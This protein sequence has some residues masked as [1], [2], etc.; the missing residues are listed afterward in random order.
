MVSKFVVD[1]MA[2]LCPQGNVCHTLANG[3]ELF[4]Y[5]LVF[6]LF[7]SV[8]KEGV[9]VVDGGFNSQV[10]EF[11]VHLDAVAAGPVADAVPLVQLED[12]GF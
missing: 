11:V 4:I 8:C 1:R 2:G 7:V 10:I 9:G 6:A 12:C 3:S 5:V